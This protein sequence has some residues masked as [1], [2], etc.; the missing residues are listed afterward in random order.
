[1]NP[2]APTTKSNNDDAS[3][4]F[5]NDLDPEG[6]S[7]RFVG[8]INKPLPAFFVMLVLGTSVFIDL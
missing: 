4:G 6:N 1:M 7:H 5:E 2:Y 3:A 8:P